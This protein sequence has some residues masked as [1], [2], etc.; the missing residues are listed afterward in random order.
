MKDNFTWR[1]RVIRERVRIADPRKRSK[2]F[3]L[4]QELAFV[5]EF[6]P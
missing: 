6:P 3:L 5:L 4:G 2:A 1:V